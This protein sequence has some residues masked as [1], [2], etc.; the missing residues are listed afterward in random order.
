MKEI[1]ENMT[2][3]VV[4]DTHRTANYRNINPLTYEIMTENYRDYREST[5]LLSK[6]K[7]YLDVL[8]KDIDNF[9]ESDLNGDK[10]P[11]AKNNQILYMIAT[12]DPIRYLDIYF[13]SFAVGKGNRAKFIQKY[14]SINEFINLYF[15]INSTSQHEVMRFHYLGRDLDPLFKASNVTLNSGALIKYRE[16]K[17]ELYEEIIKFMISNTN[18]KF[19]R[20]LIEDMYKSWNMF[21]KFSLL[22]D[23]QEYFKNYINSM[24]EL[25]G[26]LK[27]LIFEAQLNN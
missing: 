26:E 25:E 9:P 21:D 11:F 3:A 6:D 2:F 7:F 8:S 19:V 1:A 23:F 12:H 15:N 27:V 13:R 18:H 20:F 22:A 16:L 10:Y 4:D 24:G 17:K 5:P 14:F